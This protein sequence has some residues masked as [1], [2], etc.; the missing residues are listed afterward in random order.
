MDKKLLETNDEIGQKFYHHTYQQCTKCRVAFLCVF[1]SVC[2]GKHIEGVALLTYMQREDYPVE[3]AFVKSRI[4]KNL[5]QYFQ[6]IRGIDSST[7]Y[8]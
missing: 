1:H 8:L 7:I 3:F 2:S 6:W 4:R 5:D